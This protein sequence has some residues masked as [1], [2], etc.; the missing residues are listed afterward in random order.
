M[1]N[2]KADSDS[3]MAWNNEWPIAV[4]TNLLWKHADLCCRVRPLW[5][6]MQSWA[7][8]SLVRA[9]PTMLRPARI[10]TTALLHDT[11]G[12][13]FIICDL[14]STAALTNQSA[15]A[16]GLARRLGLRHCEA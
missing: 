9:T 13:C 15:H 6:P 4:D 16:G 5:R 14:A 1:A 11:Y 3:T 7:T 10:L 2:I 12:Q 8:P